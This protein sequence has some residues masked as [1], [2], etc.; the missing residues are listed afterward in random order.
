MIN[1]SLLQIVKS[2]V[3]ASPY[4]EYCKIAYSGNVFDIV[5]LKQTH[6]C[7]L[8]FETDVSGKNITSLYLTQYYNFIAEAMRTSAMLYKNKQEDDESY[9]DT[10]MRC[11]AD[12]MKISINED[13]N[14][15]FY[16]GEIELNH[17]I[18]GIVPCYGVNV[19]GL[20]KEMRYDINEELLISL[21]KT[22]YTQIL[23]GTTQDYLVA[24]SVFMLLSYLS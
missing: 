17:L 11:V 13:I 16:L 8:P 19:T 1:N 24:T 12:V 3:Q 7:V 4:Y 6:V 18:S 23:R 14:R 20:A 9:L 21:N 15:V 10:V 22:M 2:D 5:S